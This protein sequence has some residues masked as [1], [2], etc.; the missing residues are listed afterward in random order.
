MYCVVLYLCLFFH[1][2][3]VLWWP[4]HGAYVNWSFC[5]S[6]AFGSTRACYCSRD[7][8]FMLAVLISLHQLTR[9]T[10]TIRLWILGILFSWSLSKCYLLVNLTGLIFYVYNLQCVACIL[11]L[12]SCLLIYFQVRPTNLLRMRAFWDIAPCSLVGVDRRFKGA[13]CPHHQGDSSV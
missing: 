5:I 3:S 12:K 9:L 11:I 1:K 10:W 2:C 8:A 6:L 4:F 13:Y 7:G